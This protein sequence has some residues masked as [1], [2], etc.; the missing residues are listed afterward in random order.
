MKDSN[1]PT[2]ED[3]LAI[4]ARLVPDMPKPSEIF[5]K[6]EAG[7]KVLWLEGWCDKCIAG[8]GFPPKGQGMLEEKL[9]YIREVTPEFLR[10]RAED[11]GMVVQWSGFIPLKDKRHLYGVSWGVFTKKPLSGRMDGA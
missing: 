5:A 8:K 7:D 3:V 9:N 10:R 6:I 4:V 11:E 2:H 1:T